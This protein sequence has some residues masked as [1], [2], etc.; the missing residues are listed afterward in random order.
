MNLVSITK[1]LYSK[2]T[3]ILIIP[4]LFGAITFLITRDLPDQFTSTATLFTGITSNTGL[5]MM[6]TRIDNVQT[7]NEYNNVLSIIKSR[8]LAEETGLRLLAQHLTQQTPNSLIINEEAFND[9]LG[10]VPENVKKLI[11]KDDLEKSYQNLKYNVTHDKHGFLYQL[12]NSKNPY[13]SVESI[14]KLNAERIGA[15]D[16][17]KLTYTSYDPAI[18]YNTIKIVTKIFNTR[19]ISIKKN[20]SSNAIAYFQNKLKEVALQ[21]QEAEQKLLDYNISNNI[22]NYNEQTEQITTQQEKLELR[23]QDVLMEYEAASAIVSKLENEIQ[24]RYKINLQNQAIIDIRRKITQSNNRIAQLQ[25]YNEDAK[26]NNLQQLLL[27]KS[28]LERTLQNKI[29]SIYVI[30]SKTF[31]LD[32][33]QMMI[34]WINAIINYESNAAYYKSIKN[35]HLEF[36]SQYKFLAPIGATIKR[37]E[38][39]INI[40]EAEY[41]NIQNNLSIALQKE[42]NMALVTDM[43][44]MDEASL[45][46][47]PNP[48]KN[49]LYVLIVSI[50]SLIFYIATLLTIEILDLRI[51]SPSKLK[52]LSSLEVIGAYSSETTGELSYA[53]KK[54]NKRSSIYIYEKIRQ[55][56]QVR[57]QPIIVQIISIWD[58]A[59]KSEIAN[60][61]AQELKLR[62]WNTKI[63]NF[64]AEASLYSFES[65][66]N[67]STDHNAYFLN[68]NKSNSYR[69]LFNYFTVKPDVIFSILPAVNHGIDNTVLI[70]T[71]DINIIV[72]D[73]LLTW[74]DADELHLS[75]IKKL[76][77]DNIFAV[78]TNGRVEYLVDMFGEIPKNRSYLRKKLKKYLSR[79]VGQI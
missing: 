9:L 78:L 36:M 43:K 58:K 54:T 73:S 24:S 45:P 32:F 22:I 13:Y 38:R 76:I 21:L 50:F 4:V 14:N 5:E 17:I 39:E 52:F 41:L 71:A 2:L 68:I 60:L 31:G 65:E 3:Y 55:I 75:K 18:A 59:G 66:S 37:Y 33:Q 40:I 49:I 57:N 53:A 42:Q 56:E 34:E 27:N 11:V 35:R 48:S 62:G 7:L 12:L 23:M 6:G 19:Y 47:L 72:F 79:F 69:E 26:L 10:E 63:F 70:K 15:S 8:S 61:I 74:N 25:V 20:Q 1:L 30:D 28:E 67:T 46:L 51:K 64:A 44:M 29:D 16:L 77:P